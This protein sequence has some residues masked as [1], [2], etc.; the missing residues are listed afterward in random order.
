MRQAVRTHV[1]LDLL[2]RAT[3]L[4]VAKVNSEIQK[5]VVKVRTDTEFFA[6]ENGKLIEYEYILPLDHMPERQFR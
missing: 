2:P 5:S 3:R 6:F 1:G 4:K